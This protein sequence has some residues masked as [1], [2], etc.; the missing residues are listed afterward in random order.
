MAAPNSVV[1]TYTP[2]PESAKQEDSQPLNFDTFIPSHD[3]SLDVPIQELPSISKPSNTVQFL[4]EPPGPIVSQDE[5]F[6]RAMGAMYWAGYWTA[7][8]HVSC[9]MHLE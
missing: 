2:V 5:A 1:P 6:T 4:S 3:P 9:A 7:M 8:Y